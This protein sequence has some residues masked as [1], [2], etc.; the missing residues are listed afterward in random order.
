M[1]FC[2]VMCFK[3]LVGLFKGLFFD[4]TN[5]AFPFLILFNLVSSLSQLGKCINKDTTYNVTKKQ[6]HK[7]CIKHIRNKS[8][9]F[10][11]F[12]VLTDLFTNVKFNN[13]VCQRLTM[14]FRDWLR[15]KRT[16][17]IMDWK[18]W[19]DRYEWNSWNK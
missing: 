12:H 1:I 19:E 4:S 11:R 15:I 5:E 8:S 2:L 3:V 10:K 16:C 13:T 6:V 9:C 18:Y 7:D 17:I 14:L